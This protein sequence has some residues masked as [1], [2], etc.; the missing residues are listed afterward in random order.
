[1]GDE[2]AVETPLKATVFF[3]RKVQVREYESAVAGVHIQADVPLGADGPQVEQ[4]IM[5]AFFQAKS[6]VF[7]QLG[8]EFSLNDDGVVMETIRK[9]FGSVTEGA[10]PDAPAPQAAVAPR[11]PNPAPSGGN[12]KIQRQCKTCGV[13]TPHWDNRPKKASGE[14]KEKSPDLKCASCNKGVWLRNGEAA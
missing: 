6:V 1:M 4:A 11:A 12:G 3:E 14:Y 10:A 13:E 2:L 9:H 7:E 8:I 5:D